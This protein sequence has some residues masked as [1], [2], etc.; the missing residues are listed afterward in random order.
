MRYEATTEY[1]PPGYADSIDPTS[2]EIIDGEWRSTMV[3]L[4]HSYQARAN[5]SIATNGLQVRRTFE[6]YFSTPQGS[7]S[8][9]LEHINRV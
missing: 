7:V 3:R 2:G 1:A 4:D 9:Q 5:P 8:W 6:Q